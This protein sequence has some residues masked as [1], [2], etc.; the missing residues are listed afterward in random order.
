MRLFLMFILAALLS[1]CAGTQY[2]TQITSTEGKE[3]KLRFTKTPDEV[4]ISTDIKNIVREDPELITLQNLQSDSI[5]V[6]VPTGS[7]ADRVMKTY[8]VRNGMQKLIQ[9]PGASLGTIL[10]TMGKVVLSIV[11]GAVAFIISAY[12]IS[13]FP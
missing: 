1:G 2:T 10:A 4:L 3:M 7:R 9:V 13:G 6:Y 8:K 5:T 11:G 12:L